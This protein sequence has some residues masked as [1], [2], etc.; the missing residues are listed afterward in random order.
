MP[1]SPAQAHWTPS[2]VAA[3]PAKSI[4]RQNEG[5]V[6]VTSMPP[7]HPAGMA[8][9]LQ[10]PSR[11]I[12]AVDPSWTP[13]QND[14]VAQDGVADDVGRVGEGTEPPVLTMKRERLIGQV[15]ADSDTAASGR[16]R[17]RRGVVQ[18]ATAGDVA[19]HSPTAAPLHRVAGRE[20]LAEV[21]AA[22]HGPCLVEA[23]GQG[24]VDPSVA[25][26]PSGL[27]PAPCRDAERGRSAGE[28]PV[29]LVERDREPPCQPCPS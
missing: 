4:E 12:R 11:N 15:G 18:L 29:L 1:G 8:T 5:E 22:G 13:M 16:A 17:Q 2:Q 26:P 19:D 28:A 6:Q 10:E 20:E 25:V 21:G 27:R 3:S 23:E 24:V 14:A 7:F 9:S